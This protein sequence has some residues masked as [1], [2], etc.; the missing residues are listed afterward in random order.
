ML[1]LVV[2]DIPAN[3]FGA[4]KHMK[5]EL[6]YRLGSKKN[7]YSKR[8]LLFNS[9]VEIAGDSVFGH[10]LGSFGEAASMKSVKASVVERGGNWKAERKNYFSSSHG[11]NI[12]ANVLVERG[13]FGV[14]SV[15]I[16]LLV[17]LGVFLRN[18]RQVECQVGVLTILVISIAGLGQSTLHVEHGQLAL[19]CLA[20]CLKLGLMGREGD[21][22]SA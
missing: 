21:V 10:G 16:F 12:F 15:G 3:Y 6:N 13:W 5:K 19:I 8:D 14:C 22:R 20:L 17:I 11:H 4:Y 9:A 18:I 1:S 2:V 7:S